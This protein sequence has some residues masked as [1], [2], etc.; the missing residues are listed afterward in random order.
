MRA[1]GKRCGFACVCGWIGKGVGWSVGTLVAWR[2]PTNIHVNC[3]LREINDGD[4]LPM[5]LSGDIMNVRRGKLLPDNPI[6]YMCV[7]VCV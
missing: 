7:C 6:G 2:T 3:S 4:K 1:I 5:P